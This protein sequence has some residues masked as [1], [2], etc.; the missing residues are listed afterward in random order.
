MPVSNQRALSEISRATDY[1]AAR[2][3]T[4]ALT[5]LFVS[6]LV[7]AGTQRALD[8]DRSKRADP[9]FTKEIDRDPDEGDL[10]PRDRGNLVDPA[11]PAEQEPTT[12]GQLPT[13]GDVA[14][15]SLT[16]D[17]QDVAMFQSEQLAPGAPSTEC[18]CVTYWG[19]TPAVVRLGGVARGPLAPNL[20]LTIERG[21]GGGFRRC[22]SFVAREE[23]YEGT[24]AGFS[25][26]YGPAGLEAFVIDRS[27]SRVTFRFT[28]EL[29]RSQVLATG[30][31]NADF[32][33]QSSL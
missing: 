12:K 18:I 9:P 6:L 4:V 31:A 24:L 26:A 19:R 17:D 3:L 28:V 5:A 21:Q 25:E 11:E 2:I 15:V 7:I 33:W 29:E 32:V 22:K 30:A 16:D 20:Q 1:S 8:H 10:S 23:I 14:L 13:P 27:P